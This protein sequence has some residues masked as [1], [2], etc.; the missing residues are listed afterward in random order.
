MSR[1][2]FIEKEAR[3]LS[4]KHGRPLYPPLVV[5]MSGYFI[6]DSPPPHPSYCQPCQKKQNKKKTLHAGPSC[7]LMH[8]IRMLMKH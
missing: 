8:W 1:T 7:L 5:D 6:Q 3:R 2:D 4:Q